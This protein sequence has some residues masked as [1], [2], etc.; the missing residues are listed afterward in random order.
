MQDSKDTC[1]L[2]AHVLAQ[3]HHRV[4]LICKIYANYYS[5]KWMTEQ[6]RG[7][8]M[9]THV[10]TKFLIPSI[11][12]STADDR[13]NRAQMLGGGSSSPNLR[14]FLLLSVDG[15]G[16]LGTYLILF[17]FMQGNRHPSHLFPGQTATKF[18]S[19]YGKLWNQRADIW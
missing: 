17:C 8:V 4:N 10:Y 2:P 14:S 7:Y 5:S 15:S 13:A 9:R 19:R 11:P 16:R 1:V 18:K 12:S 6:K 3:L